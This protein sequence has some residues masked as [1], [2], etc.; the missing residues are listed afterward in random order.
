[1]SMQKK[2]PKNTPHK[3]LKAALKRGYR[4]N[5]SSRYPLEDSPLWQ[6]TSLHVLARLVRL[7]PEGL[8]KVAGSPLY[9]KFVDKLGTDKERH[10]Q[11]PLGSTMRL[12]YRL[13]KLLD[14]IQRPDFLHSATRRRS[15]VSNADKHRSH[16]PGHVIVKTDIKKFY[17]RT[18]YAHVKSFFYKNLG[19]S[20]DLA[21]LMATICTVDGHLPTGSCLSP[22]L[23]YF[24]HRNL[25]AEIE[26][27]C[28]DRGVTLTLYVDDLTLS[29]ARASKTFMHEIKDL[30]RRTNLETHKDV[31]V[32]PGKVGMVTGV[33]VD[34]N[35]LRLRNKQH[36]SIVAIIDAVVDG[37]KSQAEK[38]TGK[39]AAARVVEPA[40]AD[41]L[42]MR[43]QQ[44][45]AASD[46]G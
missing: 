24:V 1:M 6:M 15:N 40:A 10:V 36:R 41:K 19:W 17:E 29:G 30:I 44:R 42:A 13:A 20:Y 27:R 43:L 21:K 7:D 31:L 37:D 23:S 16:L 35:R 32:A 8:R 3:N 34:G 46:V 38:L 14:S 39:L 25:F 45:I 33:A 12:H 26:K 4:K 5:K 11:E 22:I 18:T 9:N 2:N 28:M